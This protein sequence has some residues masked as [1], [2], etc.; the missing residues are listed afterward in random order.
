MTKEDTI[1]TTTDTLN[2]A[3]LSS[4]WFPNAGGGPVH[5]REVANRLVTDHGCTVDVITKQS[6]ERGD[7]H[8]EVELLQIPGTDA[9]PRPFTELL[10]AIETVRRVRSRDYNVVHAHTNTSTVPSQ[11]IR[12][13]EAP[14]V[15]TVHGAQ[16]DLSVTYEGEF[17]DNIYSVIQRVF[18][19]RFTYDSVVTVS[20]ELTSE[21]TAYHDDVRY[22]P[23]GVDASQ[24]PDPANHDSKELLFVGRLRPKKNVSDVVAA[25]SSVIKS[26]PNAHFNV[27]GDGP[28]R[29]DIEKAVTD[30]GLDEAVTVHGYVDDRTLSD[31][32]EQSS[33]FV[34]PS[35]WEGHPL[36][37]LEA[38]ASG[39]PVIGSDV[40]G[41]RE[42][43]QKGDTGYLF[44][45]GDVDALAE[46]ITTVLD[47]PGRIKTMGNQSLNLV[48]DEYS[49]DATVERLH[50]IYL[51]LQQES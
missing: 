42:Y 21:L 27:V 26:H 20:D 19:K 37:L 22:V 36:V 48:I 44:P 24:F 14:V 28:L 18:L 51:D 25:M 13:I 5:V 29:E 4:E 10:Y 6:G 46:T 7:L 32:Y 31:L 12:M 40:E 8:K 1:P 39:L 17:V 41:I 2:V 15:F 45:H 16:L 50:D 11:V 23:N 30:R 3:L 33:M 43:V 49:W 34:L 47:D 38:G 35:D 9:G